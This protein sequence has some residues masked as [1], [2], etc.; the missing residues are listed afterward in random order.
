MSQSRGLALVTVRDFDGAADVARRT[1]EFIEEN[2]PGTL[3]W[4]FFVDHRSGRGLLYQVHESDDAERL[5]EGAMVENGFQREL[6]E[7]ADLDEVIMLTPITTP[8]GQAE[9]ERFGGVA[10]DRVAGVSR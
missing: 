10:M 1:T 5:Y 7:H 2:L 9:L 4:E 8:E 6:G 3:V